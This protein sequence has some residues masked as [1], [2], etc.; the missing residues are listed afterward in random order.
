MSEKTTKHYSVRTKIFFLSGVLVF[1]MVGSLGYLSFEIK[2]SSGFIEEQRSSVALSLA[3]DKVRVQFLIVQYWFN[4]FALSWQLESQARATE[5]LKKFEI[6]VDEL[7][8]LDKAFATELKTNG[9]EFA[10]V[11]AKTA[12]TFVDGNRILGTQLSAKSRALANNVTNSIDSRLSNFNGKSVDL[13]STTDRVVDHSKFLTQMSTGLMLFGFLIS[14]AIGAW[15]GSQLSKLLAQVT[16]N[17]ATCGQQVDAVIGEVYTTSRALSTSAA[18]AASFLQETAASI[19]ELSG[20]VSR[21]SE[22]SNQASGLSLDSY[23]AAE[24]GEKEI[25]HLILSM[26]DIA[27]SSKKIE[28]IISVIDDIAFQTNLLALNAAVEAARAGEQ[29]KGFAVVA[30]AVRALAQ[31]SAIAAEDI[32]KLIKASVEKIE[33][34]TKVADKG[35][36]VLRNIVLSV[37]KISDLNNE[38]ATAS[39]EQ[40]EGISQISKTVNGMDELTQTNAKNASSVEQ[41]STLLSS[42]AKNLRNLVEEMKSIIEGGNVS[43]SEGQDPGSDL[44][45]ESENFQQMKK[46]S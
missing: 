43:Q 36:E 8:L 44:Q 6:V 14:V 29:G 20:M 46:V 30:E 39:K 3:I 33:N 15:I 18:T 2:R 27:E 21:N 1:L 11:M 37:K 5:E 42:E 25:Q 26:K 17:I 12:E 10:S 28:E 19:E 24:L 23:K 7:A 45:T 31:R 40:S 22:H 34:G 41:S 38:I 9:S 16:E 13:L 32:S 4:E 35:S